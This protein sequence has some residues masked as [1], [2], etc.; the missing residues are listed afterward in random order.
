MSVLF[1][2]HLVY[3]ESGRTGNMAGQ[4]NIL[5]GTGAND[6]RYNIK[7]PTLN[8]TAWFGKYVFQR[9]SLEQT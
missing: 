5:Q 3:F 4:I 7:V 2:F 9:H 1:F 8:A 6:R